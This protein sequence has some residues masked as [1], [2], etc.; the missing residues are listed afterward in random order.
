MGFPKILTPVLFPCK[1]PIRFYQ[2]IIYIFRHRLPSEYTS[3]YKQLILKL[4]IN[5]GDELVIM[6]SKNKLSSDIFA[7]DGLTAYLSLTDVFT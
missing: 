3:S 7:N 1:L 6:I 4:S 2:R 5:I